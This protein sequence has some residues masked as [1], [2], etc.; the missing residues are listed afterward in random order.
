MLG[1]PPQN[2]LDNTLLEKENRGFTTKDFKGS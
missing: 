1:Y 2:V